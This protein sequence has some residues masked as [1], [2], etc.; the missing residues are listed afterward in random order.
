MMNQKLRKVSII[1]GGSC[2]NQLSF[3]TESESSTSYP[4]ITDDD[5]DDD[6]DNSKWKKA[7]DVTLRAAVETLGFSD[8][9]RISKIWLDDLKTEDECQQRALELNLAMRSSSIPANKPGF[10]FKNTSHIPSKF[11]SIKKRREM[12]AMEERRLFGKARSELENQLI[13]R[14]Y[15]VGQNKSQLEK[16]LRMNAA[17]G[18]EGRD[19]LKISFS[20]LVVEMKKIDA[21]DVDHSIRATAK[22]VPKLPKAITELTDEEVLSPQRREELVTDGANANQSTRSDTKDSTRYLMNFESTELPIESALMEAIE[23]MTPQKSDAADALFFHEGL[24]EEFISPPLEH[25]FPCIPFPVQATSQYP[26]LP[27]PYFLFRSTT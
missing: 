18:A 4:H 3:A 1:V 19:E 12:E 6:D 17:E 15:L 14:A 22:N 7:D 10:K 2:I 21:M 11:L 25:P 20:S 13:N 23:I 8:W 27:K 26:S 24:L 9:K 5:D 16:I